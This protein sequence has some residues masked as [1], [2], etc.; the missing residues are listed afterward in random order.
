MS[1]RL[2]VVKKN[3]S[4]KNQRISFWFLHHENKFSN[5]AKVQQK[6][7]LQYEGETS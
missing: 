7:Q 6:P 5:K 2:T 1:K 4:F 3:L